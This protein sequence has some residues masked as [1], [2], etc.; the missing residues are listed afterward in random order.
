MG[1][2]PRS[3]KARVAG[4]AR[5]FGSREVVDDQDVTSATRP[6][7]RVATRASVQQHGVAICVVT[8]EAHAPFV[9]ACQGSGDPCSWCQRELG[10]FVGEESS[11][12]ELVADRAEAQAKAAADASTFQRL[13]GASQTPG[14]VAKND[15][16]LAEKALRS[17]EERVK[18][19]QTLETECGDETRRARR[20]NH[21]AADT[22][23]AIRRLG[24]HSSEADCD[25]S[26]MR[27]WR[28]RVG[29]YASL[30]NR[31]ARGTAGEQS[32][33]GDWW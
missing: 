13:R 16:E 10:Q 25:C 12:P 17:D 2:S 15:V 20:L 24:H 3:K 18:A 22:R 14:A 28:A 30:A 26:A 27:R 5:A 33:A 11:A 8:T 4:A 7:S 31:P 32:R 1:D 23:Q 29:L 6:E 19:V 21:D 9:P